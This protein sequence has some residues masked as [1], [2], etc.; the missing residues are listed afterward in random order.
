MRKISR[1]QLRG[2]SRTPSDR[3]T[4]DGG[5]AESLNVSL[6]NGEIAPVLMP[7]DVTSVV[8]S[9][10]TFVA[11]KVFIH[12]TSSYT[13]YVL[14]LQENNQLGVFVDGSFKSFV[15]LNAGETLEDIVA[16]GNTLV[17]ATSERMLYALYKDGVYRNLG[18]RIPEPHIEFQCM[19]S[20][21]VFRSSSISLLNNASASSANGIDRLDAGSWGKAVQRIEFG[22]EED[23]DGLAARLREVQGEIWAAANSRIRSMRMN[24]CFLC[25]FFV[26]YAVRLY[27]GSYIY[28]SV[29][30]LL[31]AGS[32]SFMRV[33]ADRYTSVETGNITS[34][35][36]V[37]LATPFIP[38]ATLKSWNTEG[39]GDI[40]RSV[41]LFISTDVCYPAF[42]ANISALTEV[43]SGAHT[44][45]KV[46]F[47]NGNTTDFKAMESELLSKNTFYKIA[48]FNNSETSEL[49]SGFRI[50]DGDI[51]LSED[52]LLVKERLPDYE[53]SGTQIIPSSLTS[54]NNRILAV[55]SKRL[56]PT[57]YG[58]LQSTNIVNEGLPTQTYNL[59]FYLTG[60][61][62][63]EHK[64]VSRS[65][66]GDYGM[67][68]YSQTLASGTTHARPFGLIFFPDSRC[69]RADI[70]VGSNVYSIEMKPHPLLNCSY[71]YWGLSKTVEDIPDVTAGSTLASFI[72]GENRL[73]YESNRLYISDSGNP[74]YFPL[75]GNILMQAGI[76][77]IAIANT[78]L[79]QGQFGQFPLYAFT[80]DGIW[81][82]E[83]ASDGAVV[84]SKP[85][86]REVC[87]SRR[88]IVSIDQ[89]VVFVSAKG[90]MLLQGSQ[91]S[92]LS[93]DMNGRH[94]TIEEIPETII[95][96]TT[97]AGLIPAVKDRDSFKAFM[98]DVRIAYDYT[99]RRLV[100]I[101]PSHGYQYVYKLDTA[102]WHKMTLGLSLR[103]TVNS[104]PECLAVGVNGSG[105][106]KIYDLSTVLDVAEDQDTAKIVIATRPFDLDNPDIY[107]TITG[108][109]IRGQYAAGSVK[110]MLL[111]SHDGINFFTL[112]TLRGKSWK[113]FRIIILANLKPT[114]RISWIDVEYE[115][116]LT[117]RIR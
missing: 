86:S 117:N 60:S 31:G 36:S 107:K 27:D 114:E 23:A 6:D 77:D 17:M 113:M 72:S 37:L 75:S 42:N 19:K 78:A 104:Y 48:S 112:S 39:W 99:G 3:M 70:R 9:G 13:N 26:R 30:V 79:S 53:Q 8:G 24:D 29:P 71:A 57:G 1:I 100:F 7:E 106:T 90:V 110:F 35:I 38:K 28:Q 76:I 89:A 74:F 14:H 55:G 54:F 111:G 20:D 115:T 51:S 96:G 5:C 94:Y 33:E 22:T 47:F 80:A 108:V 49:R 98:G 102:T 50:S 56:L 66:T 34:T 65:Y 68:P 81:A 73:E 97:Y 63:A 116:R 67:Y 58:F 64:I 62:G 83:T 87:I 43:E 95:K 59:A 25:P 32:D 84:S 41:D 2:I 93:P 12:K 103:D 85:L 101:S 52:D 46:E 4:D 18:S 15:A 92:E 91:I 88:S 109:R 11:K 69:S 21:Y 44:T 40:I 105:Y 45:F 82:L 16:V 61:D 10:N